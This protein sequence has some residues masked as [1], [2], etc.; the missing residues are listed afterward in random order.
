MS[1]ARRGGCQCG[2]IR[3]EIT[4]PATVVYACHC[5]ECQRQSGSAFAMALVVPAERFRLLEGVPKSFARAGESGRIVTGWFCPECGTRL[6]H[7][8][9]QLSGNINVKPGTL[10][11]TSDLAPT[12][13]VWT[14]SAQKWVQLPPGIARHETQPADRSWLRPSEGA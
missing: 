10:D 5:R 13:H 3:Y 12:V 9:G 4:G 1:E 8:P 6:Y 7:T 11:N 2:A 14:K